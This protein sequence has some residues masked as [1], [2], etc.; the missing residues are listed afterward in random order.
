MLDVASWLAKQTV[1][2]QQ[3]QE[4]SENIVLVRHKESGVWHKLKVAYDEATRYLVMQEALWLRRSSSCQPV[5]C[6]ASEGNAEY[7]I[8]IMDYLAGI[9]LSNLLREESKSL[10]STEIMLSLFNNIN[11]LHEQGIVHNDIKPNNIIIQNHNAHLIDLAS[12]GWVNQAY[13][14]KK[15]KSFTPAFSLPDIYSPDSFQPVTDW[16]AYFLLLDLVKTGS[17]FTLSE[18]NLND[19]YQYHILLIRSY[20]FIHQIENF[21]LKQLDLIC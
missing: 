4:L 14:S 10:N 11:K 5:R 12:A 15:F 17:V 20:G 6:Y 1:Y 13:A 19:F 16:Y 3:V 18:T 9:S 21:L 2:E 7:Q 8:I